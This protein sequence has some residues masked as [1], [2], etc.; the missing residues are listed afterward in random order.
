MAMTRK[1]KVS[2]K[3]LLR[4]V[5]AQLA[6][7]GAKLDRNERNATIRHRQM[8]RATAKVISKLNRGVGWKTDPMSLT[9]EGTEQHE[10]PAL[11]SKEEASEQQHDATDCDMEMEGPGDSPCMEATTSLKDHGD[12]S[13]FQLPLF[14]RIPL[15]IRLKIYGEVLLSAHT[16]K[17]PSRQLIEYRTDDVE[18]IPDIDSSILLT[19]RQIYRE[20]S[21][22]L[23]QNTFSFT[24][25]REISAFRSLR[26]NRG[27]GWKRTQRMTNVRLVIGNRIEP[28]KTRKQGLVEQASDW[29]IGYDAVFKERD[30]YSY[31]GDPDSKVKSTAANHLPNLKKLEL[32]FSNWEL[33]RTERFSPSI[34]IG[35]RETGWKLDKLVL[36]GLDNHEVVKEI[37]EQSLLKDPPPRVLTGPNN[38]PLPGNAV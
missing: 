25:A 7:N 30:S 27:L 21:P 26:S 33:S 2:T 31:M 38:K 22:I 23:Y 17:N 19:S 9:M 18:R 3:G 4:N 28:Y 5:V 29:A 24:K 36:R 37:L 8:M 10:S 32:D 14:L 34:L 12:C 20:A 16:I 35:L 1:S 6:E 11:L 13:T 15:E